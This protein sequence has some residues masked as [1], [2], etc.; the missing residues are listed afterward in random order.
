MQPLEIGAAAA[1]EAYRQIKYGQNV[2]NFLYSDFER[3][4]E[5]LHAMAIAEGVLSNRWLSL[6]THVTFSPLFYSRPLVA[7][8]GSCSRPIWPTGSVRCCRGDREQYKHGARSGRSLWHGL[9]R[10]RLQE[11]PEFVRRVSSRIRRLWWIRRGQRIRR[12]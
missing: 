5:A 1:Y 7:G 4:R 12:G 6:T 3:Q 8:H 2:Y 11:P 10:R 9:R